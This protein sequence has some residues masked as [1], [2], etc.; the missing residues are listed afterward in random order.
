MANLVV[1]GVCN[2]KCTFCFAPGEIL[3]PQGDQGWPGAH[4]PRRSE[5]AFLALQAFEERLDFLDRSGIEEARFI[6]GE[7][8]LH[9]QFPELVR[10][11]RL[12]NKHILVF[13]NGLIKAPALACLEVLPPEVCT[14]VV[15]LNATRHAWG[16]SPH[17]KARR[18]ATLRRLG[19]RALPGFTIYQADFDLDWLLPVILETGTRRAI[20]LGLAQPV[21]SGGNLF[22]HPKQYPAV[23]QKIVRLAEHAGEA[24]I[25]LEFDCG[26][27]RCMF[28]DAGL[29]RLREAQA[30][31]GWRCSPILDIGL[32]GQAMHCFPLG[33][34]VRAPVEPGASA[35]NLRE[36]L[37]AQTE[38]FRAAGIYK[39]CSTCAFKLRGECT[40][41][42]LSNT[43]LRFRHTPNRVIAPA[44]VAVVYD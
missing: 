17:E 6:G 20:R 35:R 38:P 9:P 12:R 28:S 24:G 18:Y 14:V 32:D 40:G 26:F 8:T 33:A 42:C 44:G 30:F 15:N 19:A 34:K 39:E 1:A 25:R 16:P 43:L 21:L 37:A 7:P 22:L 41:G 27:V 29:D 23:G 4:R 13:S 11:A 3:L 10:R 36:T 2:L 31:T 5:A